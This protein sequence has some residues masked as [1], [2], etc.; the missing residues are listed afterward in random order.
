MFR[1]TKKFI[2][3]PTSRAFAASSLTAGALTTGDFSSFWTKRGYETTKGDSSGAF[4]FCHLTQIN[5]KIKFKA[6][7]SAPWSEFFY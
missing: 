6:Q 3:T 4:S 7:W 1:K 5:N 2:L